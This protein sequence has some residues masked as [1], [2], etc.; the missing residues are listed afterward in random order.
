M[1]TSL[2]TLISYTPTLVRRHLADQ[3]D[4]QPMPSVERHYAALLY[5]EI[6]GFARLTQAIPHT[7]PHQ[8]HELGQTLDD[9]FGQLIDHIHAHG[10]EI[11]KVSGQTLLV[12]WPVGITGPDLNTVTRRAAACALALHEWHEQH[13]PVFSPYPTETPLVLRSVVDAGSVWA[14]TVGGVQGHWEFLVAGTALT[15]L[16]AIQTQARPH[17][18]L[19]APHAWELIRAYCRGEV[20]GHYVRLQHILHPLTPRSI[21]PIELCP[22]TEHALRGYISPIVLAQ[23]DTGYTQWTAELRTVSVLFLNIPALFETSTRPHLSQHA[24]DLAMREWLTQTQDVLYELQQTLFHFAGNIVQFMVNDKGL[25]LIAAWGVPLHTHDD[26]AL[27]AIRAALHLQNILHDHELESNIGVAS[28]QVLCGHRGNAHRRHFDMMGDVIDLAAYLMQLADDDVICDAATYTQTQAYV[29]FDTLPPLEWRDHSFGSTL[30][31]PLPSIIPG[32]FSPG[33]LIGRRQARGQLMSY[34]KPLLEENKG[35]TIILEGEM[36]IGKSRFLHDFALQASG[37]DAFCFTAYAQP[38]NRRTPYHVWRSLFRQMIRFVWH[39]VDPGDIAFR[40]LECFKSSS[41]AVLHFPLLNSLLAFPFPENDL[42]KQLQGQLRADNLNQLVV[43]IMRKMLSQTKHRCVFIIDDAQDLDSASWGLFHSL[44]QEKLPCLFILSFRT[45]HT[46]NLALSEGQPSYPGLKSLFAQSHTH[47]LHLSALSQ[48]EMIALI[49]QRLHVPHI[50]PVLAHLFQEKAKGNPLIA[51]QLSDMLCEQGVIRVLDGQ[52]LMA[53]GMAY[54][55]PDD[56]PHDVASIIAQRLRS[57][58]PYHRLILHLTSAMNVPFHAELLYIIFVTFLPDS[59]REKALVQ[60]NECL[61]TLERWHFF[62]TVETESQVLYRFKHPLIKEMVYQQLN[63]VKTEA[64][65]LALATWY[66]RLPDNALNALD[67]TFALRAWHWEQARSVSRAV[68]LLARLAHYALQWAAYQETLHFYHRIN[69]L[70]NDD[71]LMIFPAKQRAQWASQ[72]SEAHAFLGQL[73]Q[74]RAALEQALTLLKQP[75]PRT[76]LGLWSKMIQLSVKQWWRARQGSRLPVP[77]MSAEMRD[78]HFQLAAIYEQ[79]GRLLLQPRL[80]HF[81]LYFD[82]DWLTGCYARLQVL[83]HAEAVSDHAHIAALLARNYA[84]LCLTAD[85]LAL[86]K[87]AHFY[88]QQALR[89]I[90]QNVPLASMSWVFWWI[91]VHELGQGQWRI[92]QQRFARAIELSTQIGDFR[93]QLENLNLLSCANY[94]QGLFKQNIQQSQAVYALARQQ[95]DLQAQVWGLCGQALGFLRLGELDTAVQCLKTVQELPSEDIQL[96]EAIRI[97]GLLTLVYAHQGLP[98]QAIQ[99][100]T[101]T[102]HLLEKTPPMAID[103]LE[104]YASVAQIYLMRWEAHDQPYADERAAA[105][106][107]AKERYAFARLSRRACGVLLRYAR[108]FPIA[109]PRALL[110]QGL[111]YWLLGRHQRAHTLW[112]SCI[113]QAAQLGMV[114]EEGLAHYELARHGVAGDLTTR[115]H[116]RQAQ[117]IFTHLNARDDLARVERLLRLQPM[118]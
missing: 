53:S 48:G 50:P 17:Q 98:K 89:V 75:L 96:L 28:G 18:V 111:H 47:Y 58:T 101:K 117:R 62:Q 31:R 74:S 80:T 27:R 72:Q 35:S 61:V 104:S 3:P 57:L 60:M 14:A 46:V 87:M 21:P 82:Y 30:Y 33:D 85:T 1:T 56:F 24:H 77:V 13:V 112:K 25:V 102:A 69:E 105:P 115:L 34:L 2:E 12:L 65:H 20:L 93:R 73:G 63:E 84:G 71:P 78:I 38:V 16:R 52:C 39:S 32:D 95:G 44:H 45:Q 118:I 76:R 106:L 4:S 8:L 15:H 109:K 92:S 67:D 54:I 70:L 11:I 55:D 68:P 9:Y 86:P 5:T 36:G 7:Q 43:T 88:Q 116:L 49:C 66:D 108:V 81:S 59:D 103:L 51:E 64:L 90:D 22:E 10:G 40:L 41:S 91:G 83:P 26:D 100:A 113:T 94:H 79:L 23:L 37:E 42:S 29:E 114:Y 97:C 19:I 107:S 99:M 6:A 110:W